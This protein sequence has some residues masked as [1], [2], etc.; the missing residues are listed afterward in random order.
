MGGLRLQAGIAHF[1]NMVEQNNNN[2]VMQ[3]SMLNAEN[4]VR[5][6][7]LMGAHGFPGAMDQF[8]NTMSGSFG[9]PSAMMYNVAMNG[10]AAQK[11]AHESELAQSLQNLSKLFDKDNKFA[12]NELNSNEN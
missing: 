11:Q 8:G 12:N 2:Q 7:D 10:E 9:D 1:N 3:D 4:G 5:G 6:H